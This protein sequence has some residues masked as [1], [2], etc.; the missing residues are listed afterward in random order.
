M[1]LTVLLAVIAVVL[2]AYELAFVSILAP[3]TNIGREDV[4][5]V[6]FFLRTIARR[7]GF[8]EQSLRF[9]GVGLRMLVGD[10][11]RR[12]VGCGVSAFAA[13]GCDV[14]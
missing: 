14:K 5:L 1:L 7:D 13:S 6:F 4:M 3:D 9:Q 11:E 10:V 8:E 2:A 12:Q